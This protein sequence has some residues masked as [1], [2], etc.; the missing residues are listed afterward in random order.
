[1]ANNS[2]ASAIFSIMV[3]VIAST[4]QDD[5]NP[6]NVP[7]PSDYPRIAETSTTCRGFAPNGWNVMKAAQGDLNK[8]GRADCVL[9]VN[10]EYEK[11]LYK[12]E[13]FGTDLF[14]TNPRILV[15]AFREAG[16]F[17]L[18]EQNNRLII[19]AGSPT[20]TE[21]FQDAE[22][23]NGVLRVY[24][25]EFYSMGSYFMAAR[26]YAFRFQAGE[27]V[28]I[29]ADK[30]ETHRAT[31][32]IETRSYNFSTGKMSIETGR[33]DSR[34]RSKPRWAGVPANAK[35]TLRSMPPPM[36]WEIEPD[37]FL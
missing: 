33:V 5:E 3:L 25:E 7:S 29:G 22:I 26:S 24:F 8:D 36:T 1:M 34:R 11:F 30:T 35:H 9:V 32:R 31:G 15:I 16:G 21:P 37:Y 20:M 28:L 23:K 10:G 12:N 27:F 6:W 13:G 18:V 19:N 4:S 2:F 17:R 14:D